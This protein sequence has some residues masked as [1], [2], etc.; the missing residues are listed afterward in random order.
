MLG[1]QA[2]KQKS[3]FKSIRKRKKTVTFTDP[4]YVDYS[5]INY[6]SD[7]DEL[8]E[9]LNSSSVVQ[10]QQ[11]QQ[12]DQQE[13]DSDKKTQQAA[14]DGD[15][16]TEEAAKV[17]PLKTRSQKDAPAAEVAKD[18]N[19]EIEEARDSEEILDG[20]N[21]TVNKSKYGTVRNTDSFYR[22]ETV[23]TKKITLTP[24]MLLD[25]DEAR[26]STDSVARD[27]KIRAS[28]EKELLSDKEKKKSKDK[29]K[30]EKDKKPS[31]IRSFF[32]R[33]D[34]RRTSEDDD[35]SFGK[36]SMD[37]VSEPR[38]SEDPAAVEQSPDKSQPTR[39]PSKLQKQQPR[40][41]PSLARKTNQPQT[42]TAEIVSYL[43]ESRTNDVSNVPPASMRIVDPETKETQ[44]IPSNQLQQQQ[45]PAEDKTSLGKSPVP[46]T[47]SNGANAK[48][49]KAMK[50]KTRMELDE[51]DSSEVEEA[52]LE[53]PPQFDAPSRPPPSRPVPDPLTVNADRAQEKA[54]RPQ[55]PGAFP[56]SFQTVTSVSS[57]HTVTANQNLHP[58]RDRL[59][60]SP[61]EV[62][63]LSPID[64]SKPPELLPD[65]V[66]DSPSPEY[67]SSPDFSQVEEA[68]REQQPLQPSWDDTKLRAFFDQ[69]DYVRDL[70][71]VVYGTSDHHHASINEA[72]VV[73]GVFRE[74]NARLAEMTTVSKTNPS[75]LLCA[76]VT[77][78]NLTICSETGLPGSSDYVGL[79]RSR[80]PLTHIMT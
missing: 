20:R 32:S 79:F 23:E 80:H 59:S 62:S 48:P 29:D 63:P 39:S 78:R 17:E 52:L 15:E 57:D 60:E 77:N 65:I 19:M 69:S 53:Q 18:T 28:L 37:A 22:D 10:Q 72:P 47:G 27:A 3:T 9:M 43:N 41:E 36:R 34:K 26:Q 35:E 12:K 31:A 74:Q 45:Q 44:E 8:E 73:S 7:E 46:R 24:K 70:L 49:Q 51:S 14:T 56:D 40:L 58:N 67:S 30:K 1:D 64:P 76:N 5:D 42:N 54:L 2:S 75:P 71:T 13:Q 21:E 6:S 11:Q 50:A 55:L 61:V 68:P 4:T 38:D 66:P 16:I 25:D 33:K